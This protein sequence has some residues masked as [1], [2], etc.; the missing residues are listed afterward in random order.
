M[1]GPRI[2]LTPLRAAVCSD[3]PVTLDV[4]VRIIPPAPEAPL[5]RPTLNI[6]LVLDRSG[7]MAG[8]G[9]MDYARQAAVFAVEQLLPTDRVSVTIFDDVVETPVPSTLATDKAHVASLIRRIEPRGSTALHA[10]WKAGA[11][12]VL[13]NLVAGGLNRVL[14]LSDGLANAGVT[15]PNAIAADAQAVAR[16]GVSTTTLGLGSDYNEDLMEDMAKGGDGNYYFIE[17]PRQLADIF[18]TELHGLMATAGQKV[19]LG[20]EPAAD[21][22]VSDV[23][24]DFETNEY[25][26]YK[27]PHLIVGMPILV[28]VRVIVP[29]SG[30][31][32][33]CGFRLAWDDPRR[34][35]RQVMRASLVMPAVPASLWEDLEVSPEVREQVAL[36]MAARRG[37]RRSAPS[38]GATPARPSAYLLGATQMMACCPASPATTQEMEQLDALRLELAEGD[39]KL[40]RKRSAGQAHQRRQSKPSS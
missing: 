12:Q 32:E 17:T 27:L 37:K 1:Q 26:R 11:E 33:V 22:R 5:K 2:E 19:S 23:L 16:G 29:A 28:V 4:L 21:A 14:L 24:N 8:G 30:G 36:L 40:F 3:A 35:G 18:Q 38:T 7:S 31:G 9:K 25:G 15:D 6:G 34:S 10:G 13:G 39:Q 20:V